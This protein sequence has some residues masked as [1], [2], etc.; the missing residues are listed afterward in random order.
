[1]PP[2][3]KLVKTFTLQ[4]PAGQA[5]PAP[6]VG[7][8]LGQHGVNIM[9]F[10]KSYNSQTESQRGDIVPAEISVY[11]DRTFTFVLK[12]P[13]AARLLIKAAGVQ[14]GSGVPQSEKVGSVTRAQ[15]REIAEKKMSDL[16]AND[17]DQAE[18]II[19]GTARSMGI[20]VKE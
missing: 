11:E 18:K 5:T 19:A 14:K 10:C 3:K 12:T 17:L 15:L 16:N 4:L 7:P 9:E 20:T 2:K 1:M 6:P 13:P 8:A